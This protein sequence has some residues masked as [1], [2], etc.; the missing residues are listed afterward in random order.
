[1]GV[2]VKCGCV[3]AVWVCGCRLGVWVQFGCV[4]AVWGVGVVWVL[5]FLNIDGSKMG[6]YFKYICKVAFF[7]GSYF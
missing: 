6:T 3:G 5:A 4:G 2:W 1:V 7:S